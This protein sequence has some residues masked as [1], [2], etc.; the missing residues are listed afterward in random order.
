MWTNR[1]LPSK[2]DPARCEGGFCHACEG[3]DKHCQCGDTE[4]VRHTAPREFP[5][6]IAATRWAAKHMRSAR[7]VFLTWTE[8]GF[9]LSTAFPVVEP[10]AMAQLTP[11][12]WRITND[13]A[14]ITL[15]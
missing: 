9:R 6:M 3:C 15:N 10:Y 1:C 12:G 13:P 2:D 5:D 11:R 7:V 14:L 8:G 4:E